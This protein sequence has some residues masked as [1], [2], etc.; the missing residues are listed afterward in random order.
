MEKF[1]TV[2]LILF[3]A[4]IVG[5][6]NTIIR[7]S[8][9]NSESPLEVIT[10]ALG[11]TP[12]KVPE[13]GRKID[14]VYNKLS[15]QQTTPDQ[16][17]VTSDQRPLTSNLQPTPSPTA[18]KQKTV[19]PSPTPAAMKTSPELPPLPPIGGNNTL[20]ASTTIREEL[21][22]L[23]AVTQQDPDSLTHVKSVLE[24]IVNYFGF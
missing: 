18:Q 16:Q 21:P 20:G 10:T 7:L 2:L 13:P 17:P 14:Y 3:I 12:K 6:F 11:L 24:N 4:G 19:T 15:A 9:S 5:A 8:Q 22:P 1:K 23:P